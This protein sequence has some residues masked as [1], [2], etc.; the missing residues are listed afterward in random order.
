M[1]RT[2]TGQE[3]DRKLYEITGNLQEVAGYLEEVPD[4][5]QAALRNLND[6][7]SDTGFAF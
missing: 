6:L 7:S 4:N 1:N 5:L 3:Q 2:G